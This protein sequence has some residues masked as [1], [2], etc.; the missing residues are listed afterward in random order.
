MSIWWRKVNSVTST[1]L[2]ISMASKVQNYV[3]IGMQLPACLV[4]R[5]RRIGFIKNEWMTAKWMSSSFR[6][7]F[8]AVLWNYIKPVGNYMPL[9]EQADLHAAIQ[10]WVRVR[11]NL[12]CE[13]SHTCVLMLHLRRWMTWPSEDRK[14][15]PLEASLSACKM[16]DNEIWLNTYFRLCPWDICYTNT[17]TYELSVPLT[18]SSACRHL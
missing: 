8:R 4:R 18:E 2:D 10:V 6:R 5:T 11:S 16:V 14:W 1:Q 15:K 7:C 9:L 17:M 12:Q 3:S 13:L